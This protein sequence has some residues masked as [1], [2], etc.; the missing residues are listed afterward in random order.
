MSAPAP[1][2]TDTT[3]ESPDKQSSPMVRIRRLD[4]VYSGGDV[5]SP[6]VYLERE[7][8]TIGRA[9]HIVGPLALTDREISRQHAR[10][11]RRQSDGAALVA[12]LGS[13]NGVFVNRQRVSEAVLTAG[14]VVR[15]GSTLLVM[16]EHEILP[17]APLAPSDGRILGD[18]LAMQRVRGD[19]ERVA[20]Q[21]LPVLV[22][23]PTGS[24]KE[25]VAEA[26][27][28]KSGRTGPFV[29]VNCAALPEALA[30]SELFGHVAG[31]FT[32]ATRRG[33]GLLKSA[34]GGTLF[35]DEVGELSPPVQA[36]LLRALAKGEVRPVGANENLIVDV[37]VVAA[38]HRDLQ[39]AAA[40]GDFRAD[41]LA[42]L[43]G[44]TLSVPSLASRREDILVLATAFLSRLEPRLRLGLD[45][46][47]ALLVHAWPFNVRQLEQTMRAAAIAAA[48]AEVLALAHLPGD[49]A[50]AA[51]GPAG[52]APLTESARDDLPLEALVPRDRVPDLPGL[53]LVLERLGGNVSKVAEYFGKDR[54]Q[55]Y[56]WAER[57]G[58]TL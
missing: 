7:P 14:D 51:L 34:D 55:I 45:A 15:V 53:T 46:A 24:G 19:V 41:L 52:P 42:R 20:P 35:L 38:T 10:I 21:T 36:K 40:G 16:V 6:V 39:G 25:L 4:V 50:G 37:R 29:A 31:A 5:P 58:V 56:R 13:R 43:A 22:L 57:L 23:G 49:I 3:L 9:P 48:D 11:E 47:E 32:G 33:E 17:G 30:E 44:W 8:I 18:S 26:I 1:P 27:H 2:F 28:R 12:D 54:K